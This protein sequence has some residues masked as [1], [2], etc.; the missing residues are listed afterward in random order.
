VGR[1]LRHGVD[2]DLGPPQKGGTAAPTQFS[3]H[4]YSGQTVVHLSNC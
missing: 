1:F 3:V 4:A 2:G